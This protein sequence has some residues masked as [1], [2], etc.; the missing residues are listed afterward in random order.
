MCS[1]RSGGFVMFRIDEKTEIPTIYRN[2]EEWQQR[3]TVP[4][5]HPNGEITDGRYDK[6]L[7]AECFNGTFVGQYLEN[8]KV[9]AWRGIPFAKI[10][11]RFERS[12]MPDKS[13]KIYQAL[14]FGKSSLQKGDESELAGYYEQGEFDCLTLTVYTGSNDIKNK[15]VF[16][17]VH[18]G[19]YACGGTCDPCYDLTNLAYYHPDCVFIDVTYRLGVLGH[20]NLAA[21]DKNGKY[22]L[23][24]YEKNADKYNTANNLS[25]L[26]LIQSFRWIKKNAAAFGG[27]ADNVTI[28]GESAGG[29]FVS[30]IL[31][32]ASDPDNKF[33]DKD[34]NLFS[35]VFSMS[36]GINLYNSV[37]DAARLTEALIDFFKEKKISTIK[38][39]QELTFEELREFWKT[40]DLKG[41]FNVPDGIVLP[42]DPYKI[43]NKYVGS[44]YIVLQGCTTNEYDY[45]RAVF[46]GL[47][48]VADITHEDCAKAVCRYL[49]ERTEIM[50]DLKVTDKF[51][52]LLDEY[53]EA[54]KKEGITS[55]DEQLNTLM[56]DHY[57]Q[58]VN[59]Y[60]A[61]KQTE[62]GGTTYCYAFDEPYD[63]PYEACKAGHGIDCCYLFGNFTGGKA[64]GTKEQVDF[65]RK[66]QKMLVNFMKTGNPST[67]DVDW[68]PFSKETGYITFL[69]KERI[70]CIKGYNADRIQTA[71]KMFDESE[72]MKYALP[73]SFMLPMAYDIAHPKK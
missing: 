62:N 14:Y 31:M 1:K 2:Q 3:W 11:A 36:G 12:V 29:G 4:E 63:P 56:N 70:E 8:N 9:K 35:K 61:Q 25:I 16:V 7:A 20:I 67:D 50:P 13:D 33:I 51:N 19:A 43:Y 64:L 23:S 73:W 46:K 39:L 10:P 37:D 54:L 69:N 58:I 15:P 38:Q 68:K 28:G 18:G 47:Y 55:E 6:N 32:M 21:K 60:M 65:S 24:D 41:V 40:N 30:N 66:Y 48:T 45:F 49:T 26:D 34:E 27:N 42:K 59:Y 57:L 22:L 52:K 5:Y 44:D 71:I 53:F 72:A 17:Y